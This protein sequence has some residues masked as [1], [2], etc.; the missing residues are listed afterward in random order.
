MDSNQAMLIVAE[1]AAKDFGYI[2]VSK[3]RIDAVKDSFWGNNVIGAKAM[4]KGE[5]PVI[6]D[7][8]KYIMPQF[9]EDKCKANLIPRIYIDMHWG[10]PRLHISLK[11]GASCCLTYKDGICTEAQ[12]FGDRG[13]EFA[14]CI[15]DKIDYL[16]KK[17]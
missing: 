8:C 5:N 13:L 17:Q 14:L 7:A 3:H 2:E 4:L 11:S 10:N 15:K 12:A 1:Q 16:I 9:E 6:V